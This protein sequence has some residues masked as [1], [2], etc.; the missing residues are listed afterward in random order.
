LY[1]SQLA[2]STTVAV[3]PE[4]ETAAFVTIITDVQIADALFA[5]IDLCSTINTQAAEYKC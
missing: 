2:T 4:P 3:Q 1:H 5:D